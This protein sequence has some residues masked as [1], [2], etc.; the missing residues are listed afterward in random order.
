M[1]ELGNLVPR[2]DT[3]SWTVELF[4]LCSPRGRQNC[5]GYR[6]LNIDSTIMTH[7]LT[8]KVKNWK[9]PLPLLSFMKSI[10]CKRHWMTLIN[11]RSHYGLRMFEHVMNMSQR[12]N[13]LMVTVSMCF[14][15]QTISNAS[16]Q[17]IVLFRACEP[18][19]KPDLSALHN[20]SNRFGFGYTVVYGGIRYGSCGRTH[21]ESIMENHRCRTALDG[22]WFPTPF[23]P[24]DGYRCL[25]MSL[26]MSIDV[27]SFR[28]FFSLGWSWSSIASI[29]HCPS[30]SIKNPNPICPG[31]R[32]SF[33]SCP[34]G[35]AAGCNPKEV[36]RLNI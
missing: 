24:T 34:K 28:C 5:V 21:G 18:R 33:G 31:L 10:H 27:Y 20:R 30:L 22:C 8:Q 16:M 4:K 26:Q 7:H 9:W 3:E 2:R 35:G 1:N 23:L 36:E 29:Y 15:P 13:N 14:F 6:L 25:Q 12:F 19:K 11:C 32:W 17:R